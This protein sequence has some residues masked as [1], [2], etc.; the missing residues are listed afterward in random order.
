MSLRCLLGCPYVLEDSVRRDE[1]RG[2]EQGQMA[3]VTPR[4]YKCALMHTPTLPP[5]K[6]EH[7]RQEKGVSKQS[8][9][10][11]P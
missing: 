6:R 3:E 1:S 10:G 7:A 11:K 9:L 5:K 2:S 8:F 4:E